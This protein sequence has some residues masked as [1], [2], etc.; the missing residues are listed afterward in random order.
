VMMEAKLV[1]ISKEGTR[2]DRDKDDELVY[3]KSTTSGLCGL[4]QSPRQDVD[5]EWA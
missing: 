2:V 5:G 1:A 3:R 4:L